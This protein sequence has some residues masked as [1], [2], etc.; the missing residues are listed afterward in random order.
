S[1]NSSAPAV[2]TRMYSGGNGL[3]GPPVT[4]TAAVTSSTSNRTWPYRKF[5]PGSRPSSS[6]HHSPAAVTPSAPSS[7]TVAISVSIGLPPGVN[8]CV[9]AATK[10]ATATTM[11]P[12]YSHRSQR[13]VRP[14]PRGI[15]VVRSG[16]GWKLHARLA[17]CNNGILHGAPPPL[18]PR[19]GVVGLG[20]HG[21]GYMSGT[22]RERVGGT[23]TFTCRGRV[24]T[25]IAWADRRCCGATEQ[26]IRVR[27]RAR[28]RARAPDPCTYARATLPAVVTL[29]R[30]PSPIEELAEGDGR[31][32]PCTFTVLGSTGT[33]C[34]IPR[35]RGSDVVAAQERRCPLL[36]CFRQRPDRSSACRR[37]VLRK[38]EGP[39]RGFRLA[40][41]GNRPVRHPLLRR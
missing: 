33:V 20:R 31:Y 27:T 1:G 25:S 39:V 24:K 9:S 35:P 23:G 26:Q 7:A 4:C 21:H 19:A 29:R 41:H 37:A 15:Q 10:M 6:T 12:V 8:H 5:G 34:H 13:S 16:V 30:K 17:K 18:E 11:R 28:E 2:I 3:T 38:A 40:D 14:I 22:G 36:S 32:K